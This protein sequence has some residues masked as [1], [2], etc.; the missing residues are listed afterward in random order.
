MFPHRHNTYEIL[1]KRIKG[2]LE[3]RIKGNER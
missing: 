1:E 3:K 2:I